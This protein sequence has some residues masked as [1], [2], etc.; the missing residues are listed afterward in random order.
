MK[1]IKTFG[2]ITLTILIGVACNNSVKSQKSDEQTTTYDSIEETND[3]YKEDGN[4]QR[5]KLVRT[6]G[7]I[8][9]IYENEKELFP[10]IFDSIVNV[11]CSRMDN[12][13]WIH[14][15]FTTSFDKNCYAKVKKDGKWG[16]ITI[17]GEIAIPCIYDEIYNFEYSESFRFD[18][19][20]RIDFWDYEGKTA[21]VKKNGK[22]G[23][24]NTKGKVIADFI[25]EEFFIPYSAILFFND[26]AAV[27][28]DGLWGFLNK[29][30]K[31]IT[32]F[33]YEAV[34]STDL[35]N[36]EF[37]STFCGGMAV[38]K[39]G[40]KWG[41]IDTDGHEKVP[42]IY[43]YISNFRTESTIAQQDGKWDILIKTEKQLFL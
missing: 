7:K 5:L 9:F 14:A 2:L 6:N 30:G 11:K 15:Y 26:I 22:W 12:D 31:P 16:L 38:V 4:W 19:S 32:S 8:G 39:K 27:K 37:T 42:F 33:I 34:G 24:I 43:D 35:N 21:V 40:G 28:K 17:N 1:N 41:A 25:Y 3:G 20:P 13:K 29:K 10:C 18:G 36:P 23:L